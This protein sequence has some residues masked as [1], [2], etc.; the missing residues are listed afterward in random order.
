MKPIHCSRMVLLLFTLILLLPGSSRSQFNFSGKETLPNG[1]SILTRDFGNIGFNSSTYFVDE[2]DE[3]DPEYGSVWDA[4]KGRS[5]S[6]VVHKRGSDVI[7]ILLDDGSVYED[8]FGEA[9]VIPALHNVRFRTKI[10]GASFSEDW[11]KIIGDDLYMLSSSYVYVSHDTAL[12]WNLDTAGLGSAHVWDIAI[13]SAIH[14]YAATT[15]GLFK[16]SPDSDTWHRVTTLTQ[17]TSL[18]RVFVDRKNR[19]L[20]GGNGAGLYLSTDNGGTWSTDTAGIGTQTPDL[21]ADDIYGNLYLVTNSPFTNTVVYKSAGGTSSW[22]E[23]D[24]PIAAVAGTNFGINSI[25]G[26]STLFIGTPYGLFV[27]TDQ[28]TTWGF[29]SAGVPNNYAFGFWKSPDG[30]W[31]ARSTIGIFSKGPSDASWTKDFPV[32][33]FNSNVAF[34]GDALGNFYASASHTNLGGPIIF[35]S[36]DDG[37]TWNLDTAGASLLRTGVLSIDENGGQHLGTSQWGSS[38]PSLLFTKAP[39]GSW[40][41]DTVG[42]MSSNYSFTY[43]MASDH[44]GY[45]YITGSYFTTGGSVQVNG[46][47]MRRPI[48]GGAWRVDTTGLPSSVNYLSNLAPDKDGNMMGLAGSTLYKRTNGVWGTVPLPA[49][50]AGLFYYINQFTVDSAG[51]IFAS[52]SSFL[53]GGGGIYSTTDGGTSWTFAGLDSLTVNEMISYGDSTYVSTDRGLFVI[54]RNTVGTGVRTSPVTP[55]VFALEQNYPNPFNP[56][57]NVRFTI[58]S[59]QFVTLKIYDILGREVSTLVHVIMQAGNYTVPWN[60]SNCSSGIY[61]YQLKAGDFIQTKKMILMK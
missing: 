2:G 55:S 46:R 28:G 4:P 18:Y 11:E 29:T 37:G 21:F 32:Q 56:A 39:G 26:D 59:Q 38:Y 17:S 58:G 15:N 60:A 54:T 57:T 52:F 7:L 8:F 19:I 12:T 27:S 50:A 42:F 47:V 14:V 10:T 35:K 3:D 13:D 61:F 25:T 45:L 20:V 41:F 51:T 34:V 49:R 6:D 33:G 22:Q 30:K 40:V 43:S 44:H 16:E 9:E 5:I 53:S 31:F 23:I 36:T 1:S 24:G 48:A